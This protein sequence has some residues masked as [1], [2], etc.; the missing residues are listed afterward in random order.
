[1]TEDDEHIDFEK[2]VSDIPIDITVDPSEDTVRITHF[3]SKKQNQGYAT[4]SIKPNN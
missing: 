3:V 4:G 2:L 1:M